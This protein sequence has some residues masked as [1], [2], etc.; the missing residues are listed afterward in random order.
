LD[1]LILDAESGSTVIKVKAA[2]NLDFKPDLTLLTVKAQDVE[3]SVRK[4]R[5]FLS[6]V[7]LVTMQNG[8]RS[9]DQV[10]GL[11][12]KVNIISSVVSFNGEFLEPGKALYSGC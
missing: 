11:L 3:S 6:A 1:G 8:V 4:V 7:Q 12:G 9:D 10:A 2:E 5:L